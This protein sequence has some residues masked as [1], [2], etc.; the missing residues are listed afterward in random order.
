[1]LLQVLSDFISKF[2][3][4]N[5]YSFHFKFVNMG[6][7]AVLKCKFA[8]QKLHRINHLQKTIFRIKVDFDAWDSVSLRMT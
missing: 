4:H 2:Y 8:C 1:M 5:Y 6:A 3:L 7:G